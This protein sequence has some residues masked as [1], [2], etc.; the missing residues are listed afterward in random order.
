MSAAATRQLL[1]RYYAAFNAGGC[2]LSVAEA[3]AKSV[4]SLP[5]SPYLDEATQ[6]EIVAAVLSFKG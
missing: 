4:I 6:D 1:E 2:D 5:F 3:K